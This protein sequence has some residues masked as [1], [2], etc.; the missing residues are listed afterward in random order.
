MKTQYAIAV[1]TASWLAVSQ[2]A[3]AIQMPSQEGQFTKSTAT[4]P[5]FSALMER[6]KYDWEAL[7]V[8]TS[9]GY[10]LTTFH[11]TSSQAPVDYKI[12][13]ATVD[14]VIDA[15]SAAA[16]AIGDFFSWWA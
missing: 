10:I 2:V 12:E 4:H 3:F 5:R 14:A 9:D 13:V 1:M 15:V 11:I 16:S 8:L 6:Y 7:D